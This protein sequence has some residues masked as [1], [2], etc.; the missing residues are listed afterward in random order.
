MSMQSVKAAE[1]FFSEDS[2]VSSET[3]NV[4]FFG[5]VIYIE[6]RVLVSLQLL[7]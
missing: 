6:K 2:T 3:L 7:M 4:P 5:N 1:C